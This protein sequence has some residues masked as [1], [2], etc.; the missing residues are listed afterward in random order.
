TGDRERREDEIGLEPLDALDVDG[1]VRADARQ[2][3]HDFAGIVRMVVDAHEE[4]GTAEGTDDLGIRASMAD[5]S[6]RRSARLDEPK[7]SVSAQGIE[8]ISL[9]EISRMPCCARSKN[10]LQVRDGAVPSTPAW[11]QRSAGA[12][13]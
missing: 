4:V 13:A 2:V 3:A 7:S 6:H 11:P 10:G 8:D 12:R 9:A 1:E 5:D